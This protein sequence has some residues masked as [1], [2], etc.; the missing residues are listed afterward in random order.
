MTFVTSVH[1]IDGRIQQPIIRFLKDRYTAQ[2]VDCITEVSPCRILSDERNE[3]AIDQILEKI[4]I[5][6]HYH[7]SRVIAL[8]G[9][10]DCAGNPSGRAQQIEQLHKGRHLLS[11][12][13]PEAD[14]ICLWVNQDWHIEVV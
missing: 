6:L 1:C 13:Y 14:I 4:S 8:S 9:H 12:R 11:V 3:G 2:Y 5:S 7:D 10:H